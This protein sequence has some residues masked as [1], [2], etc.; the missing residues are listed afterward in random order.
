MKK[1][2]YMRKY[3]HKSYIRFQPPKVICD[4]FTFPKFKRGDVVFRHFIFSIFIYK[5]YLTFRLVLFFKDLEFVEVFIFY[6]FLFYLK[7]VD[8]CRFFLH[9]F[10]FFEFLK[11]D[12]VF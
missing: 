5:F 4:Y 12:F 3:L 2:F 11:F 8:F 10:D 9:F 1:F 6:I 7:F